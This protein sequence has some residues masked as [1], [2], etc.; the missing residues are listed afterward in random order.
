M[1]FGLYVR[2]ALNKAELPD[3]AGHLDIAKREG[4]FVIEDLWYRVKSDFRQSRGQINTISGADEYV[5]NKHFDNF[6]PHSLQGP[7]SRP[8]YLT[9]KNPQEFFRKIRLQQSTSGKPLIYTFGEMVGYDAQLTSAS[10]IKVFS[11]LASKTTSNINVKAGSDIVT[12]NFNI[13]NLNDVGLRLKRSGDSLTYKIGKYISPR[14]IQLMEKYRGASGDNVDYEIGDVGIQVNIQG[15]IGGEIDSENVELN[16]SNQVVTLKTVNTLVS[17]GKSDKTG[18]K[19][20]IQTEDGS[21]TLGTLA[22][23]D[24]EIERQTVLLWPKPD[25]AETLKYRFFMKHP[26]LWLDSDRI[27]L[28]TKWH[29]LASYK[30]EKRLLEWAGKDVPQGLIDDI[31]DAQDEFEQDSEDT[32]LTDTVPDGD[33]SE[34]GAQYYYDKIEDVL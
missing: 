22:P 25:G 32:S 1:L 6:V 10:K 19:I 29:R 17:I 13:F 33:S 5:L 15:F 9:Y 24:T 21:R 34:H 27:L 8:D 28:P 7:S 26:F 3:D 4:N 31:A 14:R 30:L 18:G 12:S 2:H 20:T 23:G 11:S 16:G